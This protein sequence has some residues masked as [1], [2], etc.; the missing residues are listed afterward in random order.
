MGDNKE[1]AF[2]KR[3]AI[4]KANQMMFLAVAGAALIAGASVVVMIYLFRIFTFNA[5]VLG[6]QDKS[7]ATIQKNIE[8]I[9]DLKS[10]L[11]ALETDSNLNERQ[12]KSNAEDGGLRV[13]ADSLPDSENAAALAASL[14]KKIFSEGVTLD[15]FSIDSAD[16]AG[17][18]S[19]GASS[20]SSSS[21]TTSSAST[22]T[23][24]T[25]DPNKI[26][27]DVKDIQFSATI[28]AGFQ[29]EG[30]NS[31]QVAKS[32]D[33]ALNNLINTVRKMEKSIRAIN[34]TSFKFERS[35]NRFSINFSAKSYY[36]PKYVM[37]LESK[38]VKADESAKPAT[39]ATGTNGTQNSS[40][41]GGSK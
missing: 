18:S 11:S 2:L 38:K 14:E 4:N 6:E 26:P 12:L 34:I 24:G 10:K 19:T 16:S 35:T 37:T 39:S 32:Q 28:S 22:T 20:S 1:V 5:K 15:S 25:E 7:I 8:N 36:Y 9:E 23:T 31:A 13:I 27:E 17:E 21:S 41:T 3:N 30:V 40:T 33:E 29:A